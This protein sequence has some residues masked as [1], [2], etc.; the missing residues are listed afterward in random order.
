MTIGVGFNIEDRPLCDQAIL[1]QLNHD[2]ELC[3]KEAE[4]IFCEVWDDLCEI[5][6]NVIIAM[7]FQMGLPRFSKFKITIDYI[8]KKN[9]ELAARGMLD[10]KWAKQCPKR[11]N[12]AAK[13]LKTG[14][15]VERE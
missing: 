10:S 3:K 14:Q 13:M 5:R 9:W 1:V 4:R 12:R 6:Q 8:R 7:I 2:I 15:Y 11:A